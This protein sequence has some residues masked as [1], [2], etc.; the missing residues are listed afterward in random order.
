[1]ATLFGC[2]GNVPLQIGKRCTDPL[3]TLKLLSHGE[4]SAKIGPAYLEIFDKICRTTWTCNAISIC[5]PVLCRNYRTDFHQKF[6]HDIVALV[7]LFNHAYT[8]RYPIPFLN[9]GASKC[10]VYHF[11]QNWLPWQ[12]PLRYREKGQGRSSAPKTLSFG[13]KIAKIGEVD[14]EIICLQ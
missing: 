6:F 1:M 13:E 4:K 10:G 12:R 2:H 3:S 14:P 7:A 11:S 9:A 5:Q 8:W